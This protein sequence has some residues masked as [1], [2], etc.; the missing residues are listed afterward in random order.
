MQSCNIPVYLRLLKQIYGQWSWRTV[1][2]SL[3]CEQWTQSLKEACI[4]AL[5]N[6]Q[7]N[8]SSKDW[9]HHSI[10]EGQ[11]CCI[12]DQQCL[13]PFQ[14]HWFL[15]RHVKHR[16]NDSKAIRFPRCIMHA[17]KGWQIL[18]WD[19]KLDEIHSFEHWV[20]AL[21]ELRRRRGK[22]KGIKEGDY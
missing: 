15:F 12:A 1:R 20:Y 3:L 13:H 10:F 7:I 11:S 18:D 16:S 21:K 6:K 14:G 22:E 4:F 8:L 19:L 9:Q 2:A 17:K 5:T